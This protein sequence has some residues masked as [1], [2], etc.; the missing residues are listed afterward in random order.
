MCHANDFD[1]T[2]DGAVNHGCVTIVPAL[3]ALCEVLNKGEIATSG[4]QQKKSGIRA[5]VPGR[6]GGWAGRFQPAWD[7]VHTIS[8]RRMAAD[9]LMGAFWNGSCV[10]A[11]FRIGQRSDAERVWTGLFPDAWK[12]AGAG[13]W[14]SLETHSAGVQCGCGTAG[15]IVRL[16]GHHRGETY[17][18]R[19]FRCPGAVYRW[20][21]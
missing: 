16:T 11:A 3:L 15:G 18:R 13:R 10:R 9:D 6:S 8:A 7:G 1:D 2:H 17:H 14:R 12:P 5:G 4:I 20:R 19:C 21:Y